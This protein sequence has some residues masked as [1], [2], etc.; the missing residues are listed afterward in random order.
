LPTA[1]FGCGTGV[2]DYYFIGVL[3]GAD[4]TEG[5]DVP[6]AVKGYFFVGT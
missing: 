5:L 6:Y 4:D 2:F 3:T 1:G